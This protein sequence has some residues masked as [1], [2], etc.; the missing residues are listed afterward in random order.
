MLI[1]L[2]EMVIA[3][4]VT[5]LQA[6]GDGVSDGVCDGVGVEVGS[7]LPP[8]QGSPFNVKPAGVG[9][10]PEEVPLKL[11][12]TVPPLAA[13]VP[14]KAPAGLDASTTLPLCENVAFVPAATCC[15]AVK[16][17]ERV[18][19]LIVELPLFVMIMSAV[20]LETPSLTI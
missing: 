6:T 12:W 2:P 18:Y 4:C 8:V 13:I 10:L 11:N 9:L 20:K 1:V 14:L 17:Q 19:P 5:W 16:T 15:P 7:G 3:P